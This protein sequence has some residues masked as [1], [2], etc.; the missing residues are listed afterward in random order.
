MLSEYVFLNV[1][2]DFGGYQTLPFLFKQS[3]IDVY[4][5]ESMA[6]LS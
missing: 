6:W 1:F 2:G 5:Q 3:V 4:I